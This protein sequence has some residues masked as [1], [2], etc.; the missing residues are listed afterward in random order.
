MFL[1]NLAPPSFKSCIRPWICL[2]FFKN[3]KKGLLLNI[4]R[5]ERMDGDMD[6]D[7]LE[8]WKTIFNLFDVDGDQS[9][10]GEVTTNQRIH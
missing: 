1:K 5:L 4:I 2:I 3:S 9:I 6:E 8:E 7:E 10:T